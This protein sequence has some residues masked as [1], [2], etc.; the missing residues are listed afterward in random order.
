M[1]SGYKNNIEK[2]LEYPGKFWKLSEQYM[3]IYINQVL[4]VYD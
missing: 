4:F 2:Y 1:L 3:L